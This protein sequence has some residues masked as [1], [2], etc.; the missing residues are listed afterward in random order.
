MS[1]PDRFDLQITDADGT[2]HGMICDWKRQGAGL[3]IDPPNLP[4]STDVSTKGNYG[5]RDAND[6][7]RIIQ[8]DWS[9]G[10]AQELYDREADSENAFYSSLNID[11]ST[12]GQFSLGPGFTTHTAATTTAAL[13][14]GL[15]NGDGDP[16]VW[17]GDTA[18]PYIKYS[19]DNSGTWSDPT[20][21]TY[22]PTA[23]PT[24][25][26]TDGIYVYGV[27]GG[28][29]AKVQVAD[30]TDFSTNG[31]NANLTHAAFTAGKLYATNSTTDQLGS[32][33]AAAQ[34]VWSAISPIA[35]S[36]IN[37]EGGTT[38]ALVAS[39]N[40]VYWG[41]T[42]GM[43]TK[44]YKAQYVGGASTDVLN[45]VATF[46]T[47]FVGASMYAYLDDTV[48]VGGHFDGTTAN[49]GI[50]AIYAIVDDAP[51]LLT[52]VGSD[53]TADN[54]VLAMTAYE[55][56]LYFVSNQHIWRWDLVRGGY[57]HYA[58]PLSA[59][60]EST[61]VWTKTWDMTA[62]PTD[63]TITLENATAAYDGEATLTQ[64]SI[65]TSVTTHYVSTGSVV[66]TTGTT[67]EVDLP[68]NCLSVPSTSTV[69]SLTISIL[70]SVKDA[71]LYLTR[72]QDAATIVA[73][74]RSGT[75]VLADLGT[76]DIDST[77]TW[78]LTLKNGITSAYRDEI[79]LATATATSAVS[80]AKIDVSWR[81]GSANV[82]QIA[83]IDR[84]RWSDDG[85]YD[86]T[87]SSAGTYGMAAARDAVW[88]S[89]NGVNIKKTSGVATSGNL[90]S[91]QSS[92]NMPTVDKYLNALTVQGANIVPTGATLGAHVTIDGVGPQALTE[93]ATKSDS[94]LHWFP[95]NQSGRRVQTRID[96]GASAHLTL[97]SLDNGDTIIINGLTF[98]AH[99]NTTTVA[100]RTFSIAGTDTADAVEL[101]VCINDSTYGVPGVTATSTGAI[102]SL[103]SAVSTIVQVELG[104][105]AASEC[106][107]SY[108]DS[109]TVAET[110]LLFTPAPKTTKLFTYF[111]ACWENM[112]SRVSGLPWDED[113]ETV[114]DFIESIANTIVTVSRPGRDD[115]TGKVEGVEYIEAPPS[116]RA[117]GREGVYKLSV[118]QM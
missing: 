93:D 59:T 32:F 99:T 8:T 43:V 66:D 9:E 77:H 109:P 44:V 10:G 63:C 70:G 18:A 29:V 72:A 101:A 84:I 15:V 30:I 87:A 54:R 107:I 6:Y 95:I 47:G 69:N 20:A 81:T 1:C 61:I 3:T 83:L 75:T 28:H 14:A 34:P 21:T 22:D 11:V 31:S 88:V 74:L 39:K 110:A 89:A 104:T 51:A 115:Y 45:H 52:D 102:V 50:G 73:R 36:A 57:S 23:V 108:G 35:D 98:T 58:G 80:T 100:T 92:G 48:Y 68:M 116:G 25:L 91:S 67:L 76:F 65:A 40:F 37:L 118:R 46:P 111:V 7:F 94:Y 4:R 64:T 24:S 49:T 33:N 55:R 103:T 2:A 16:V 106:A 114:S 27:F 86:P 41:V 90:V 85:A 60:V 113:A 42:N 82:A 79:H 105:A 13:L 97:A 96:L 12:V 53:R 117:N 56:A 5:V 38:F 78:R 26:C 112:E 71:N 19:K 62:E 17:R